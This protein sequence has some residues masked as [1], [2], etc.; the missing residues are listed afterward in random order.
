[1]L[2]FDKIETK[3][4]HRMIAIYG[5]I[6]FG[7]TQSVNCYLLSLFRISVLCVFWYDKIECTLHK[8]ATRT[9]ECHLSVSRK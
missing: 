1:M 2:D 7:S 9:N 3:N 4:K 5:V 6:G 8:I